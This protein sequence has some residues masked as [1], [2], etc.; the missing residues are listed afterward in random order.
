MT[1]E[2]KI[3]L[4]KI[5]CNCNDC[6]YLERDFKAYQANLEEDKKTQRE[7]FDQRKQRLISAALEKE[8]AGKANWQISLH[9]AE[10]LK[11]VYFP[12]RAAILY[13]NCQK[14][15]KAI[16]FLP[17]ILQLETQHCFVHRKE[18]NTGM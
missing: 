3:E 15:N 10:Q 11:F 12:Q 16:R 6:G 5:D 17:N 18:I 13:G 9:A 2:S 4:Q 8:K 14:L 1:T 7:L